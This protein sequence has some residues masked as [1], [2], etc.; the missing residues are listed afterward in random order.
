MMKSR[1]KS[2]SQLASNN[3]TNITEEEIFELNGN[4]ST[5][6]SIIFVEEDG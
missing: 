6:E 3:L 2:V 1:Q 4:K 5:D